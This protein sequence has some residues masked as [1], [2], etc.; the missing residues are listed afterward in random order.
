MIEISRFVL[1]EKFGIVSN[2]KPFSTNNFLTFTG[3]I[4]LLHTFFGE[5]SF[6]T[7]SWSISA[8]FYTYILF[9]ALIIYKLKN[10]LLILIIILTFVI[11][12]ADGVNF[13][14]S[15]TTYISFL[16]CIYCFFIGALFCKIYLYFHKN[17]FFN[18]IYKYFSILFIFI[19]VIAITNLKDQYLFLIPFVFGSLILFSANLDNTNLIGKI[20]C[21][22]VG[23]YLGKIS[24]SIYMSHL[25]VFWSVTQILR[26]LFKVNVK[27]ENETGFTKLDLNVFESSLLV[28]VCYSLTIIFSHF[29][30][31]FVELKFYKKT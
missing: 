28:L 17:N 25:F 16:D 10:I 9:A 4:F 27:I 30:Y 21:S 26:F 7:P 8:E 22:K 23:T 20:L 12:L 5:N 6:N 11:R 14:I 2:I 19:S 15:S 13:G 31:K 3:N 1:S 24:Y 29:T 18:K